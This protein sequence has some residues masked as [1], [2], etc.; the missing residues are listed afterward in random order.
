MSLV[1]LTDRLLVVAQLVAGVVPAVS[2]QTLHGK[3]NRM[4]SW[5]I[6]T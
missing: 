2:V 1:E 6:Q 4:M 3:G 5:T